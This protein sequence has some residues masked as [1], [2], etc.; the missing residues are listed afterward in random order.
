MKLIHDEYFEALQEAYFAHATQQQKQRLYRL[1]T[2]THVDDRTTSNLAYV[3]P[4]TGH[5]FSDLLL[6]GTDLVREAYSAEESHAFLGRCGV[7]RYGSVVVRRV[8]IP[9]TE[10]DRERFAGEAELVYEETMSE[11]ELNDPGSTRAWEKLT[12]EFQDEY[13]WRAKRQAEATS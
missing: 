9:Q 7:G 2:V 4:A 12:R 11:Y 10:A 5:S 6:L 8:P 3:V 1:S 13:V